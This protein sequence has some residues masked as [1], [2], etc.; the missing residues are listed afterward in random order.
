MKIILL[1]LFAFAF[2]CSTLQLTTVFKNPHDEAYHRVVKNLTSILRE[3]LQYSHNNSIRHY[4]YAPFMYEPTENY[5]KNLF[6]KILRNHGASFEDN[7][8]KDV[9]ACDFE[10]KS[11]LNRTIY[12]NDLFRSFVRNCDCER[13][14]HKCLSSYRGFDLIGI[15]GLVSILKSPKCYSVD[16]PIVKCKK[17]QYFFEPMITFNE[18]PKRRG[19]DTIRCLEYE[20]DESKPKIYQDNFDVPFKFDYLDP[21]ILE[22]IQNIRVDL[23]FQSSIP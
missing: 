5:S 16:H 2:F 21:Q 13:K 1:V 19:T 8:C 14:Y 7:C 9:I 15:L 11:K 17:F 22:D 12:L 18:L 6:Y 20:L 10:Q 4:F 23:I 3:Y